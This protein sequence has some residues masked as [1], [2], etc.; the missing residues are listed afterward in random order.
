MNEAPLRIGVL[1]AAKITPMALIRPAREVAGVEVAAV[2][3]RDPVRAE[4]FASKHGVPRVHASYEA[5]LADD[6][7]DAIYNPLPNGLHAEW[8]IRALEA[9]KH[10]LCE[11]PIASNAAEAEQMAEAAVRTGRVLTEAFHW[12]YHPLAARMREVVQTELGEIRHVEAMLCFPLPFPNDIRY[13]WEL[14]GGAMMDAGCYTVNMVRWLAGAEPE[15]VS[16]EARIARPKVDR[17][18]RAE[19]RLPGGC[20]G[21]VTASMFSARLLAIKALVRGSEGEMHVL[22]PL[23]PHF[24]HSLKIVRPGRT[25]R[26]RV[27]GD[28]TYT[29]Q[30]RAFLEHVRGGVPMSSDA[31]DGVANMR[32]IDAV[33]RAAGLPPRGTSA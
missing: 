31:R 27:A 6:A 32:V 1:G 28:A 10:V 25:S 7:I 12:R 8:S 19:L 23:A 22:N 2:A 9:G 13:S 20:T 17:Y 15:V 3:A 21:R 5:L 24:F 26:E 33:Y 14:A 4:K 29:H 18:M 11:K 16:A 30:L